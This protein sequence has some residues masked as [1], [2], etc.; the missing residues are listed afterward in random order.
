MVF[1]FRP[2]RPVG[3]HAT[4]SAKASSVPGITQTAS[5]RSSAAEKPRVPVPKSRVTSLSLTFAGRERTLWRLKSHIS[6]TPLLEAP[7]SPSHIS[8]IAV[9]PHHTKSLG[10][11]AN[12]RG[13]KFFIPVH[14]STFTASRSEHHDPESGSL[15]YSFRPS[16]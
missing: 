12:A 13:M 11:R 7:F 4:S 5:P 10:V 9:L 1:V 8:A 3:K 6:R 2:S 15:H 16:V 14:G